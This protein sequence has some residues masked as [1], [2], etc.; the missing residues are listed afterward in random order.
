M[1]NNKKIPVLPE[2]VKRGVT[3]ARR[4]KGQNYIKTLGVDEKTYAQSQDP[5]FKVK[6]MKRH[7]MV[8]NHI[9]K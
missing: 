4:N 7:L 1:K 9:F 8:K 2:N 6:G 5:F 3:K